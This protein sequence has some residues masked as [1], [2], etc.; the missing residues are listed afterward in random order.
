MTDTLSHPNDADLALA[1][2]LLGILPNI[3]RIATRAADECGL[4]RER[5]RLLY[6]L[7]QRPLRTGLLAQHLK[8]SPATV[9]ELVDA[10]VDE[11]LVRRD[12]DPDDRRAVVLE[13]TAE[14]RRQRQRY[15]KAVATELATVLAVLTAAQQ[16]RLAA[17]F[18]DIRTA[19]TAFTASD[20]NIPAAGRKEKINAR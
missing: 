17:A 12:P 3:G 13:L 1:R 14:G 18:A 11:G 2:G 10:L 16:R 19:F 7:G 4:A 15:E 5:C 9:S 6:M 8:I 20:P